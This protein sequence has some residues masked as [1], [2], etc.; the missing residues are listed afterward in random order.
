MVFGGALALIGVFALVFPNVTTLAGTIF[1]GF[2]LLCTGLVSLFGALAMRGAGPFFGA[3]LF[4][5]LSIAA[6]VLMLSNPTLGVFAITLSLGAL[7]MV[8]G[9]SE[10]VTAFELR[11]MPGA[12][13]LFGSALAS[14]ALALL[15]L[16]GW[17]QSSSVLLGVII[18]VN[19]IS[20]GLAFV[21]LGAGARR[22]VQ[23]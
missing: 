18:G 23:S 7:F 15:V 22:S 1:V 9:A 19:F 10:L 21:L 6:G 4:S 16:A 3:L 12:G 5:L 14:I 17:P 8:Q 2:V 11:R 13:W 20:S